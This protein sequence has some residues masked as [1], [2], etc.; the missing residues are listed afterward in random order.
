[1][2]SFNSPYFKYQDIEIFESTFSF[3][4]GRYLVIKAPIKS[5]I[6]TYR[7]KGQIILIRDF[8]SIARLGKMQ[9]NFSYINDIPD[10]QNSV[11]N[12]DPTPARSYM[13]PSYNH[14]GKKLLELLNESKAH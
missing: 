3:L 6:I 12:V 5:G 7:S 8:N 13:D 9:D 2:P 1:M 10:E 14:S 4:E 11:D